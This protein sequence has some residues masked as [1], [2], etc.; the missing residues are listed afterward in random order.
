MGG[1]LPRHVLGALQRLSRLSRASTIA[2]VEALL[3]D[4]LAPFGISYYAAWIA[5]DPEQVDP[6]TTIISNWPSAWVDSYIAEAKYSYDPV[7]GRATSCVGSF[8]WHELDAPVSTRTL[9]LKRDAQ[10]YGLIDGFTV[11]WRSSL[12]TATIL[13]LAGGPLGWS[14]LERQT[15]AA[16]ADGFILRAMYLRDHNG[17]RRV[18]TLSPRERRILHLA[19]TGHSDNDIAQDGLRQRTL[20]V[21]QNTHK[22]TLRSASRTG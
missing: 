21:I 14:T 16:I 13:S 7:V 11:P 17:G 5:A 19:A 1:G 8:F 20:P 2:E 22:N 18:R 6:R 10:H 12:P 3:V 9:E 15:A 4:A